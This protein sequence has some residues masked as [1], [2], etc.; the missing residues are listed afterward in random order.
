MLESGDKAA[1]IAMYR[2][3]LEINP[4]NEDSIKALKAITGQP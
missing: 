4:K 2:R 3:S 1:A